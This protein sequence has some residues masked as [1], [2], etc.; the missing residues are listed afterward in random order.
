[1]IGESFKFAAQD[2]KSRQLIEARTEATAILNATGKALDQGGNLITE[3]ELAAVRSA[4]KGLENAKDTEDHKLIR[5]R[6][7]DV[8]K[9]T[10]HF[11]EVL[12]DSSLK[13]ALENR[14]LSELT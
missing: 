11:A 7:Q 8:E 4:L 13:Q 9:A 10:H 6:I 1:M 3:E 14:K 5:T 2:F 12:M